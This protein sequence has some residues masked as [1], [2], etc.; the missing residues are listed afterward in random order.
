MTLKDIQQEPIVHV[1][2]I[3]PIE[4]ENVHIRRNSYKK[5]HY[6]VEVTNIIM[7]IM[8]ALFSHLKSRCTWIAFI[9]TEL[10]PN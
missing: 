10:L 2:Q 6:Y 1:R 4:A 7:Y 9:K 5:I 3:G 8:A